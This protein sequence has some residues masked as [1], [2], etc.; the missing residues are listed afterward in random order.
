MVTQERAG[1]EVCDG[2]VSFREGREAGEE[3][4]GGAR[5]ESGADE[6]SA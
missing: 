2:S 1:M 4:V 5:E 3:V 6:W